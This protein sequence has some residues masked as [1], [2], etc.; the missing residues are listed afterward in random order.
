MASQNLDLKKLLPPATRN[1]LLDSLV[2]NMFNRFVS[3][4]QSV[5]VNG[6][7]GKNT[8]GDAPI[9]ASNL[10]R[11][12]NAM[13]PA[14]YFKSGTEE[15]IFTF[16][17][18]LNRLYALDTDV[19]SLRTWMAEQSFNY[20]YPINYDKFIN[21]ANY[22]WIQ[23]SAV[24][25]AFNPLNHPD[26]YVIENP[27]KTDL[28]K[29]PVE[30][31]TTGPIRFWANN[32]PLETFTIS[33]QSN[34]N[35][36]ITSKFGTV[37][38]GLNQVGV[39]S[40]ITSGAENLI[41]VTDGTD[42]L[43]SFVITVG[44]LH[45]SAGDYF[46]LDITYF[47][48]TVLISLT[49]SNSIGKGTISGVET[50]SPYMKIDGVTVAIGE[51]ILVK[52]QID[53]TENGIYIVALGTRW[54]RADDANTLDYFKDGSSVYV[55]N[56]TLNGAKTFIASGTYPSLTFSTDGFTSIGPLND[57]QKYNT[58]IHREELFAL[59]ASGI[60][61]ASYVQAT[62]P[63]IEYNNTLEL[64]NATLNGYPCQPGQGPSY[65]QTKTAFG[66]IPQF[67]LY[68][69]DGTH[70]GS[71]SG[72]F[73]YVE[74]P[75]FTTDSALKKRV[76]TTA[77]YDYIF[78]M[79]IKDTE[80]RLLYYKDGQD[81]KSVWRE[82]V[83][84][85]EHT[86]PIIFSGG[87][88]RGS[89][90][91]DHIFASADNQGWTAKALTPTT[92]SITGTR[93]G[94]VGNATIGIQ[95]ACD[96]IALTI[97]SGLTPFV[98]GE[99]FTF[100]VH[101]T[102][103]PRYV[104]KNVDG[105]IVNYPGGIAADIA[106]GNN[107]GTWMNP[108]RMFENVERETRTEVN[109]GDLLNH[110]RSVIKNQNGFVGTSFGINNLRT[111]NFNP[112]LGG[113]IREFGSNFP[114]LASMLIQKDVSP[115]TII[116][117]A[118]Q[119]YLTALS[120]ID[121]FMIND[122]P[123][124][125]ASISHV[126]VA[127]INPNHPDIQRLEEYFEQLRENN[128]VL[129]HTFSDTTALVKCWPI[130][131]PMMGLT[132]AVLPDVTFDRQLGIDTIVHHDGHISSV[133]SRNMALD[134]QLLAT[135]VTRSDGTKSAGIFS[136]SMP[137]LPHA[138]QLWF[139]PSTQQLFIF[140]VDT[141][142]INPTA[143]VPGDIWYN[144]NLNEVKI[145]DMTGNAWIA[146]NVNMTVAS[147]WTEISVANIKNSL[148]IAIE[149][150]LYASVSTHQQINVDI[151]ANTL[152]GYSSVELAKFSAKY[153]Y[154]TFAP[155]YLATDPFTW[156]YSLS[157]PYARWYDNYLGYFESFGF[158]D[159]I[160]PNLEPWKLG[161]GTLP[162]AVWNATYKCNVVATANR[163]SARVV[164][165][166]DVP[167]LFGFI[168]IDGIA[169]LPGDKVLLQAQASPVYNGLYTVSSVG[170][171][172]SS[173]VLAYQQTVDITDGYEYKGSA[174]V[175]TS[176]PAIGV[177]PLVY[178]QARLWSN[179]M[180]DDIKAVN[181]TLKLC[182]NTRTDELLPPYVNASSWGASEALL[183]TIPIGVSN[184]YSFGQNGPIEN[185]WKKSLEYRYGLCR[186]AFRLN[187]L[188]FLDKT[189]GETYIKVDGNVRV[190]RNLL[191]PLSASKFLLHGEKL[192]IIN[193]YLPSEVQSRLFGLNFTSPTPK[194]F[195]FE[196]THTA[197][198]V[199][200]LSAKVDGV[201]QGDIA[202][203]VLGS[204]GILI[205]DMGIPYELG[206]KLLATFDGTNAVYSH[207]PAMV[208][209]F[210]GFGQIFTN[211]LRYSY[212][213]T[214]LS[215]V[216]QAYRGWTVKLTHRLGA[217]IRPDTLSINTTQGVM[218][219][220][221]F[222]VVLKKSSNVRSLWISA[223][224]VQLIE[225]GSKKLNADGLF[226]PSND[227]SDWV[228]RIEGYNAQHPTVDR[229]FLDD[230]VGYET[231]YALNKRTSDI[232]WK[233]CNVKT[234][235]QTSTIPLVL[236][237]LQ[238]V[239]NFIYGYID[240]LTE[241]GWTING[242]NPVTDK[243]TGRNID[244]Q[245]EVEKLIDRVYGGML[246]DE[247]HILN[248]FMDK[249]SVTT[250]VGLLAK[251][252]DANYIDA[253]S[254]Q[255]AY[256]VT[257]LNIPVSNLSVIRTDDGAITYSSTPIFSA[258]V[259]MDEY[260]HVILMNQKFS[261]EYSSAMVFDTFLG[262]RL[263]TAY[264]SFI[265]Q[266]T[267]NGKPT[268]DGFFLSGNDVKRNM[269]SSIDA[270][271]NYYDANQTFYEPTTA[272]HAL[273][274]L[275]FVKKDYFNAIN[276]NDTTQFNFWRGLIQAKG[277]NMAIDAFVNYKKFTSASTD[278]YWAY[279]LATFGDARER[280]FPE[281]KIN[282]ADVFQKFTKLQFYSRDN[283]TYDPLPL[284]TQ[285]E[286]I[287]DTRWY[288]IDDLG[289]GM[290]FEAQYITEPDENDPTLLVPKK[291]KVTQEM[292]NKSQYISLPD[293]YHN[294]EILS[295]PTS[296]TN[297]TI[298]PTPGTL[299][300][301]TNTARIVNAKL[302]WVS[303][304]GTYTVT[305]Y[306]WN[307][308][309]KHSPIKLFDY[310][311][312]VLIDEIGLWHPAIGIHSAAALEVVNIIANTD[313][314]QYNYST[315]TT[316]NSQYRTL[317]PWGA[318][319][320]GRVF[321]D[322]SNL[323]YIPYYDA[324]IF[325]SIDARHARWG[326]LAEYASIDLYQW[327]E[328]SVHPS[329][330]N[331]LAVAEEG[332]SSIDK[333]V[334][335]SGKVAFANYYKRNRTIT[336][337]AIAWSR[338]GNPG[339]G[340]GHPAFG[341]A[342]FTKILNKKVL[343]GGNTLIADTGRVAD[344]NLV[345]G[346]NFGAWDKVNNK[347]VGEVSIGTVLSYSIGKAN[348]ASG[349]V[350]P[351]NVSI[352]AITGGLFGVRIGAISLKKR[353]DINS[354]AYLRMMDAT[355]FSEDIEIADW[356]SDDLTTDSVL[357]LKF[358]TF[359]LQVLLTRSITGTISA[360]DILN[361]IVKPTNDVFVREAVTY[362]EIIPLPTVMVND[363]VISPYINDVADPD[364]NITEYEWRT[365]EV[366][367]QT[368][369]DADLVSP[370]NTWLPYL[371]NTITT[372]AS[373]TVAAAM[374]DASNE[375]TL[376][377][378]VVIKRFTSS[379][380]NW[381]S[382]TPV[383]METVSDGVSVV[384]F[385]LLETVDKNR[386][387]LYINGIQVNPDGYMVNGM[388][389]SLV[390]K[391]GN[392]YTPNIPPEGSTITML[393]RAYH[394]TD[395][396]L[397]F[398]PD[399]ADDVTIQIQYKQDYQYTELEIRNDDGN[400][401]GKKYYF[402][403]QDKSIPQTGKSMSLEQAKIQLKSGPGAFTVFSRLLADPTTK[404]P[405][406]ASYDSCSISGLNMYVTKNDSFKLRML[407]DF[408]LRDDPEEMSLKNTHTEWALIRKQQSSKI[409]EKLW[410]ILTDAVCGMDIGGNILPSQTRVDYDLRN[411]T[412]SRFGFN[413]GQIFA[414]TTLLRTSVTNTIL[415]TGLTL[416][417]VN[418]TVPDYITALDFNK[419]DLWFSNATNAR[420][421]MNLIWNTGRAL[422]VNEIFFSALED[423]L[424]NNYEFSDMFKTSLITIN[425]ATTITDQ[426][427]MEQL[428][429]LY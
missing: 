107:D 260:E 339:D 211:L 348:D 126:G 98:V 421:T 382:L 283:L 243:E 310:Q 245:L 33:F 360:D 125:L 239:I 247:G 307:N 425:S 373:S 204:L 340:L 169:L 266:Q 128:E 185:V 89:L 101:T 216:S 429:E 96:D 415:N 58:W 29:L 145:W 259:F 38:T 146:P 233:R 93:S 109:F 190:E 398:D 220:T 394:P 349:P 399:V 26:Y 59:E 342:E 389:V 142:A 155:D 406:Q 53:S 232:A 41:T 11:E 116:D 14:L 423:A 164:A 271:G 374:K 355:G 166:T 108:A 384:A 21:Y 195:E 223:L 361:D 218:P 314:A 267:A 207:V 64:N 37:D 114:L 254:M 275:G 242:D 263:D 244:W 231:F 202:V 332:D 82:G 341:P 326:A 99:F 134:R 346:R 368:Q 31:A 226:I 213:D 284:F 417:L 10:D 371:G 302:A 138:R 34:Q 144:R 227:A 404:N 24:G 3:E 131:L 171:S 71:T 378:G 306:T 28:I 234:A 198:N 50:L 73:Y 188:G 32:R 356:Y 60:K 345:A 405:N 137:P 365:W 206:E 297:P 199:T 17:D 79:G 338:V 265:R 208:K 97:T 256:D 61:F 407:R 290:K 158:S 344:I 175:L 2:S 400:I 238:N 289:K 4:E 412:R 343:N 143:G 102:I 380:S 312:N 63:I 104:K 36:T 366:P 201:Y 150:K 322:T 288:S 81:L 270:V 221:G 192:N 392:V 268:F 160:R 420:V 9:Q 15:N 161:N 313:P 174:W 215:E 118:E 299:N 258:H 385:E 303:A 285:I 210:K 329:K 300:A 110:T 390:N 418:K 130:T 133:T 286:N 337:R 177:L 370:N 66:Q 252:S 287:D 136:E 152:S 386:L 119:Q 397:A 393:Y 281:V 48:S 22:Y 357:T 47:T 309:T 178:E 273:A 5:L 100:I 42:P 122:F 280:T 388:I 88:N 45:F 229:Y 403:V 159:V 246:V 351:T 162:L 377:S 200:I 172:R 328:S 372:T 20:T 321:W 54:T 186:T 182:V 333:S 18:M 317:K 46:T 401:T 124:Y 376:K 49:A 191:A 419:S 112:G 379:W 83:I 105:S 230:T 240:R 424:A 180:W 115:L 149:N 359:G 151:F 295:S 203:G 165:T 92:F 308:P 147:R 70:C 320:V 428:D 277:T 396:E 7:I 391:N 304:P 323:A 30:L 194:S 205:K 350:L 381:E 235:F 272:K 262:L 414:D 248:P 157:L 214:E 51:R 148:V 173:D 167:A 383:K 241:L 336:T 293:I 319:E 209:K 296:T 120:S 364:Y 387:S 77:N 40:A 6:R 410:G 163:V 168:T 251:Y 127:D 316:N 78:G 334:R 330:Y 80:G 121:Q 13:I 187:P 86:L 369:L 331:D 264:L 154:D 8:V 74:D 27:K 358:N 39:L 353:I 236:Y 12:V 249:L 362:T 375:L 278:E 170:W 253:Y 91:V 395:K 413:S 352:S 55:K 212:I 219:S 315:K 72:I 196:V 65:V 301:V 62:R 354:V 327:T 426:S 44:G 156:N 68:R 94:F 69:Y 305:G 141:D 111:L 179:Q 76:K 237:G 298:T 292:F 183:N 19:T 217:M 181:P 189:W 56:G 35:Y 135:V 408:T 255:A 294:S 75:D 67:N 132:P 422:Q 57:W 106:D 228:F 282:P 257:G 197:D 279:K 85:S 402:W 411:G 222:N 52:D 84:A 311:D 427:I 140:S 90:H 324:T 113:T 224:R 123:E 347:P 87:Y 153:G 16:E 335:A 325:P 416:H 274:L 117:F 318:R 276:V 269:S 176:T 184:V 103:T 363:V 95:F 25:P 139:K 261:D 409:P 250:P 291:I 43:I 23:W 193:S 367:T 1:E 129:K 225:M